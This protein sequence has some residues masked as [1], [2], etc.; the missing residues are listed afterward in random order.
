MEAAVER[1]KVTCDDTKY[2][3]D[4]IE[5]KIIENMPESREILELCQRLRNAKF[6]LLTLKTNVTKLTLA[7]EMLNQVLTENLF[8]ASAIIEKACYSRN[9]PKPNV[10]FSPKDDHTYANEPQLTPVKAAP[11]KQPIKQTPKKSNQQKSSSRNAPVAKFV[12]ITD[13]EYSTLDT[14]TMGHVGLNELKDL[15]QFL[16]NYSQENEPNKIIT[17]QEIINAGIKVRVLHVAL[18]FLKTLKRIDL[19]KDGDVKC[20]LS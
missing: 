2:S 19:T 7:Q 4:K 12:E 13:K 3:I 20:V 14:R 15:H 10:I 1:L 11:V 5:Q 6:R 17:K 18:R 9:L 16:W 8:P